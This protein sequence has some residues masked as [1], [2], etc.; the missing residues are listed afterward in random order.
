MKQLIILSMSILVVGGAFAETTK[1]AMDGKPTGFS[2]YGGWFRPTSS[3]VRNTYGNNGF[4]LG[5]DYALRSYMMGEGTN[6]MPSIG[7]WYSRNNGNSNTLE[8]WSVMLWNRISVSNGSSGSP[9][10]F[11]FLTGV[12]WF[13]HRSEVASVSDRTNRF[14][15]VIGLGVNFQQNFSVEGGFRWSGKANGE[16]TDGLF[17]NGRF[18]F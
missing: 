5:V 4:N 7:V 2:V 17:V 16:S 12:G 6:S 1:P 11:Y 9:F 13:N 14:G 10:G 15:G 18:R 8:T 3:V